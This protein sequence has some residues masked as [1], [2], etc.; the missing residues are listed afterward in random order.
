MIIVNNEDARIRAE[1]EL[2]RVVFRRLRQRIDIVKLDGY[3]F[4]R[5]HWIVFYGDKKSGKR[6]FYIP[7]PADSYDINRT[8]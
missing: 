2:Q 6:L 3:E 8:S 5:P 1:Q 4:Y 7:I